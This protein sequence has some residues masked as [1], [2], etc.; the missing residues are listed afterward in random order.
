MRDLDGWIDCLRQ[1]ARFVRSSLRASMKLP[2][3][4][5]TDPTVSASSVGLSSGYDDSSRMHRTRLW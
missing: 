4:I 1:L 5:S 3:V 2:D